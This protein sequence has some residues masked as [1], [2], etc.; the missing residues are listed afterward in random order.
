M[1]R[2]KRI[3]GLTFTSPRVRGEV[4]ARF[5]RRVR[6]AIRESKCVESPPHP[7]PLPACGERGLRSTALLG[8]RS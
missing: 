1:T 5:A 6:G 8:G 4:A 3:S 2:S 7:S